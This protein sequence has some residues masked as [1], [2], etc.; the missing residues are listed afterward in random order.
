MNKI[1]ILHILFLEIALAKSDPS[2][3]FKVNIGLPHLK[4]SKA[5][6]NASRLNKLKSLK[7]YVDLNKEISIKEIRK[8]WLQT[9]APFH[10]KAIDEHYNIF[11]DIFG[12]AFFLPR[13]PLSIEYRQTDGSTMPVYFG[14]QIKPNEVHSFQLLLIVFY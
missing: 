12:E 6:E 5:V 14:N 11:E 1:L 2:L 10:I 13:I 9:A 8:E 3:H 7:N 4:A